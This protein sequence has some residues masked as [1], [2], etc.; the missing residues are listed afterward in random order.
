MEKVKV[1]EVSL[2]CIACPTFWEGVTCDQRKIAARYRF[3]WLSIRL[4]A[5]G[6]GSDHAADLCHEVWA[7]QLGGHCDGCLS[8]TQLKTATAGVV[9]WPEYE[10]E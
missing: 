6:D 1:K 10:A 5:V 2:E 9:E 4:G 8:Y 7:V 3:G